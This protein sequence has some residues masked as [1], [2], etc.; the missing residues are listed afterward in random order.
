M[1]L[2]DVSLFFCLLLF[3]PVLASAEVFCIN[4][5]NEFTLGLEKAA[6]NKEDDIFKIVAGSRLDTFQIPTESG[7]L[8][9]FKSG[10]SA[11]CTENNSDDISY[12]DKRADNFQAKTVIVPQQSTT[13]PVPHDT[14]TPK[15]STMSANI[16]QGGVDITVLGVPGYSWR[17]GCGPTALGMVLGYWDQKGYEDLFAGDATTQTEGVNQGIASQGGSAT[18]GHW[19]DYSDPEDEY[20]GLLQPDKSENPVGDEHESDSIA[21][22]MRT[23]WSS[24]GN[25][26][27]WSWSSHIIPAFINYTS[28]RNAS[29]IASAQTYYYEAYSYESSLTWEVLTGEIDAQRPMVFLV[30]SSGSGDTDHFVTVVGYKVDNGIQYYGC[31]DTWSP[32]DVIRWERFRNM[33]ASYS[34]GIY[35]GYSFQLSFQM[36][37]TE[38]IIAPIIVPLLLS[39]QSKS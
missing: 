4:N 27:G 17:H 36:N 19:E 35:S 22:F 38:K 37:N 13:G 2:R 34:W 1:K 11:N 15:T 26:Y 23:S 7:Y 16:F 6:K 10:Y 28:F 30:D 3:L 24:E 21:D 8:I 31:L 5:Q 29:Y 12:T 39:T 20:P 9:Q 25:Y 14:I 33:S 32:Y 18:P